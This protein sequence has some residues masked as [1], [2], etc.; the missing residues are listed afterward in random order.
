[1]SSP[2]YIKHRP[3]TIDGYVFR[4]ADL[5]AKVERWIANGTLPHLL[6][7]GPPGTGKTT[8]SRILVDTIVGD[9]ADILD[10]NASI[11]NNVE[12]VQSKILAFCSSGGWSGLKIVFLDEFDNFS[13][14][15]QKMLRGVIDQFSET[16]RF[17]L[18]ANYP[19]LII[20]PLRA[21]RF[22]TIEIAALDYDLYIDRLFNI[23]MEEGVTM[24][25]AAVEVLQEI[26]QSTY[27]DMR[28]SI[29]VLEAQSY[30]GEL[31][32]LKSEAKQAEWEE[33]IG[34]LLRDE[35]PISHSR[36]IIDSVRRDEIEAAYKYLYDN[37]NDLFDGC[38][39]E[40]I[41]VIESYMRGGKEASFPNITLCACLIQLKR[42][43]KANETGQ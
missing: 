2:W 38:Q 12:T 4:D 13:R 36:E 17:V 24:D 42:L 40:A 6:L 1:M 39:D 9:A 14:P 27:P 31:H 18:T 43:R 8:L 34:Q 10:L 20:E 11:D 41:V 16:V 32:P 21:S 29:R 19:H 3:K 30:D 33:Q 23:L 15:A 37:I 26:I 28:A 35:A 5:K 22:E 25:E 7:V